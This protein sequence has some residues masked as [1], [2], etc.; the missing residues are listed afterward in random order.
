MADNLREHVTARPTWMRSLYM[1]LF[2]VAFNVAEIVIAFVVLAQFL[3]KLFSGRPLEQ[4]VALGDSLSNYIAEI[5]RFLTFRSE[6][7]PYPFGKWPKGTTGSKASTRK[8]PRKRSTRGSTRSRGTTA[9]TQETA[10]DDN[11]SIE[12]DSS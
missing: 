8:S 5:V 3:F 1:V 10:S 9:R 4:L 6:D 11:S 2:I 7:M 12:G